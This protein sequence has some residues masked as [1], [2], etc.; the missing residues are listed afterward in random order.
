M[1]FNSIFAKETPNLSLILPKTGEKNGL[2]WIGIAP[3]AK[4]EGKIYPEELQLKVIEHFAYD[5]RVKVF[6]FGGGYAEKKI[7]NHWVEK[8]PGITSMV[9]KLNIGEELILMSQLDV[10]YTM[11]SGNM[12]LASLVN[13]PVV[14]VWGATHPYAG[15]MGWNQSPENAVQVDLSCRPCSIY[16]QKSCYRGDYAC[17]NQINPEK[18]I[19][20]INKILF[21]F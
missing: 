4:H 13:T 8:Y 12:H 18:I 2:K 9:S 6:V 5:K 11:D 21:N 15:F 17:L 16:G 19:E 20:H 14:S 10:M 1:N 7:I 3:F